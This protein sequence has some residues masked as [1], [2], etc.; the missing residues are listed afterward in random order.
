MSVVPTD[1]QIVSYE[2]P[3]CK[4][5]EIRMN[6]LLKI[7]QRQHDR[8]SAF[9]CYFHKELS[10]DEYDEWI[11][12]LDTKI[13]GY[14]DIESPERALDLKMLSYINRDRE[15]LIKFQ[16]DFNKKRNELIHS[17]THPVD[18]AIENITK[19]INMFNQDLLTGMFE[20][21]V[22]KVISLCP[23]D[24]SYEGTIK[25]VYHDKTSTKVINIFNS[26]SQRLISSFTKLLAGV[27]PNEYFAS[28]KHRYD[29]LMKLYDD[30]SNACQMLYLG[31]IY[32]AI[33]NNLNL[34]PPTDMS[35]SKLV[36]SYSR[37]LMKNLNDFIIH[38][39]S[40]I[41]DGEIKDCI[42]KICENELL[43]NIHIRESNHSV[44][45]SDIA[46]KPQPAPIVEDPQDNAEESHHSP[47]Q[48]EIAD[49]SNVDP[50]PAPI[51]AKV[52]GIAQE[53]TLDE[54]IN[55]LPNDRISIVEL[56]PKY[57]QYFNT[58]ITPRG[59]GMILSKSSK[60]VKTIAWEKRVKVVYYAK[61]WDD[62]FLDPR[63]FWENPYFDIW[64]LIFLSHS[65][66]KPLQ[67]TSMS[68]NTSTH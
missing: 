12:E 21:F 53:K 60:L 43:N 39:V 41:I 15:R 56:T 62:L 32:N 17:Y 18:Y 4:E 54:F 16:D 28:D 27:G 68:T 23:K 48:I 64:I 31:T 65:K 63:W 67:A 57:N 8:E 26:L 37:V 9:R 6:R 7:S 25:S 44:S 55:G 61:A 34:Y 5:L 47:P 33:D 40:K 3:F 58:N 45:Q 30:I 49:V 59:L 22:N 13:A 52:H 42:G 35:D 36:K 24:K 38:D 19:D 51:V 1:N 46:E 29:S 66:W 11:R 2:A 50:Q 14:T 10:L 20:L